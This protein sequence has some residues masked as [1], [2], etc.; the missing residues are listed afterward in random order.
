MQTQWDMTVVY[1]SPDLCVV[2]R[3]ATTDLARMTVADST[4]TAD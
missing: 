2:A 3:T 1:T 4:A